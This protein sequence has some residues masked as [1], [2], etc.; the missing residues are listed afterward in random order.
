MLV[1]GPQTSQSLRT[2][3]QDAPCVLFVQCHSSS[4][5]GPI[6]IEG[7]KDPATRLRA[8]DNDNA[9]ET[10]LVG[11]IFTPSPK[12]LESALHEQYRAA[13]LRKDWFAPTVEVIG[14]ITHVAQ[15]PLR[16]LLAQLRPHSQPEGTTSIEEIAKYLGVSVPTVRR[17]VQ[18]GQIPVMRVGRTLRFLP[19]DVVASL[20]RG[21]TP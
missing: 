14:Y 18:R 2:L 16:E 11:L 3:T 13:H 21:G 15:P 1:L 5:T 7:T 9:F 20:R 10:Y 8:I 17:M 12:Q 6:K 4:G 19:A